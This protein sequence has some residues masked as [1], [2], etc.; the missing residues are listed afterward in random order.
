M[1]SP[2]HPCLVRKK[3]W[4]DPALTC[5]GQDQIARFEL[6]FPEVL[7]PGVVRLKTT[8]V[9]VVEM[10]RPA[11]E[12]ETAIIHPALAMEH[13]QHSVTYIHICYILEIAETLRTGIP[14]VL[15]L[16]VVVLCGEHGGTMRSMR[17]IICDEYCDVHSVGQNGD[18]MP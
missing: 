13:T 4:P 9:P 11:T 7:R 3:R 17:S 16:H 2:C 12:T 18:T 14:T 15:L 1:S 6:F 5:A 8:E 10:E